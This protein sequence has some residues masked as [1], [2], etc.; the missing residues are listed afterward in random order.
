MKKFL[1]LM[2]L[3]SPAMAVGPVIGY[4]QISTWTPLSAQVGGFNTAT[5]TVTN[6]FYTP[7]ISGVQCVHTNTAGEL[8]GTGADC[9]VGPGVAGSGTVNVATQYSAAYYSVPG[10]SSVVSGLSPGSAG[11]YLTTNGGSSPPSWTTPTYIQNQSTLQSGA[12]FNVSSGTVAGQLNLG[13]GSVSPELTFNLPN[14]NTSSTIQFI[15]QPSVNGDAL[16]DYYDV[17]G[18]FYERFRMT[19]ASLSSGQTDK[20]YKAGFNFE[21]GSTGQVLAY[22]QKT[23]GGNLTLNATGQLT[24]YD[25][26][27]AHFV[28]LKASSTV[29]QNTTWIL[30]QADGVGSMM[31]DGQGNL[32]LGNTFVSSMTNTSAGGV[33][34]KYN[35]TAGSATINNL[36]SGVVQANSANNLYADKISLS[37][38]VVNTLPVA[39]GGTGVTVIASSGVIFGSATGTA[40]T[41]TNTLTYG[42]LS[43]SRLSLKGAGSIQISSN[44]VL[45]GTTVYSDGTWVGGNNSFRFDPNFAGAGTQ[46]SIHQSTFPQTPINQSPLMSVYDDM[47][48]GNIR[49]IGLY[50]YMDDLSQ[51]LDSGLVSGYFQASNSA[52][53]GYALYANAYGSSSNYAL[54]VTSGN[55]NLQPLSA[56]QFV[57][58]DPSKNFTTYNLFGSANNWTGTNTYTSSVTIITSNTPNYEVGFTTTT[59]FYHIAISTSGHF[60]TSGSTAPAVS[61]C[62]TGPS[63]VG[64]DNQ[65]TV[66]VGSGVTTA[67]TLTFYKAWG[68]TPICTVEAEANDVGW[69]SAKSQTAITLTFAST[70]ASTAFDY[71]CSCSGSTCR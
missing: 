30:P 25:G 22:I 45:G 28:A 40:K 60:I 61:S 5:G 8:V 17:P 71:R 51:G 54:Y 52:G 10:S 56:S 48:D 58:T 46:F 1:L 31:S 44:T 70:M 38:S 33:N 57:K 53:V 27:T 65:G 39:N 63:I 36:L 23:Q 12:I 16:I 2:A 14:S 41:D 55:V 43:A 6:Q 9:G 3:S 50:S 62:G 69:V 20:R 24:L 68:A 64:D 13:N 59:S 29:T 47:K 49:G 37:S 34:V 66:T 18:D 32:T 19:N 15:G 42:E 67:C 26:P 11:Q 35:L 7:Y 4:V 21:N